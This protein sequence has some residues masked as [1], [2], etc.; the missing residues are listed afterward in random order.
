M[1]KNILYEN[2]SVLLYIILADIS[3]RSFW[4]FFFFHKLKPKSFIIIFKRDLFPSAKSFFFCFPSV[5]PY[6]LCSSVSAEVKDQDENL[7]DGNPFAKDSCSHLAQS[8]FWFPA[9]R[10]LLY[11]PAGNDTGLLLL[12]CRLYLKRAL[13]NTKQFN[14]HSIFTTAPHIQVLPEW[15][16]NYC[17]WS[18]TSE[19]KVTF[20]F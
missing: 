10:M 4:W 5:C 13:Q 3:Y 20:Y 12:C 8:G 11:L 7:A 17:K 2:S 6:G 14:L 16:S 18:S 15:S 1:Y 19:H 9:N